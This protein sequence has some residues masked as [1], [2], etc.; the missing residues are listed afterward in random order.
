MPGTFK[1]RSAGHSLAGSGVTSLLTLELPLSGRRKPAG[2]PALMMV[3]VVMAMFARGALA[4]GA[5]RPP[6]PGTAGRHTVI[7]EGMRFHPGTVVV[8]RGE[9]ITWINRDLFP[10]TVTAAGGGFDSHAIGPGGSWTYVPTK[11]GEYDYRCTFHPT[12]KGKVVVR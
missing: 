4:A 12:M 9:R 6:L 5:S 8:R 10:H 2:A 3:T 7:I 1:A 11:P